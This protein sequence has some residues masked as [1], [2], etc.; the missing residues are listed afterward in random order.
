MSVKFKISASA[1]EACVE[2]VLA[3]LHGRGLVAERMFPDQQRAALARIYVVRSPG[4]QAA[5]VANAL[6][7]FGRDVEY[8]E[9]AVNRKTAAREGTKRP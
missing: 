6:E 3:A 8:V 5:E 1:P 4:A 9:G 7:R 2:Q